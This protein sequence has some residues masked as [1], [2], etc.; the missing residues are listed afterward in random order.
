MPRLP[1]AVRFLLTAFGCYLLLVILANVT[2]FRQ[3]FAQFFAERA[4][5]SYENYLPDTRISVSPTSGDGNHDLL[6]QMLNTRTIE[7]L[8]AAARQS[9]QQNISLDAEVLNYS[10]WHSLALQIIVF[11]A[12]LVASP[13]PWK[14]KFL[15]L[16]IGGTVLLLL[17]IHRFGCSIKFKT[18]GSDL[19]EP[20]GWSA[21]T[22]GY[23][24][25]VQKM[26]SIEMTFLITVFVWLVT[27]F[28]KSDLRK[29]LG[30]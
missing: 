14:R 5:K 17:S 7:A 28:R 11:I 2:D 24:T 20:M 12:L 8:E 3:G 30:S 1:K 9:G 13:V 26:H 15:S 19:L 18:I 22:E 10:L 29:F 27:T 4:S 25:A 23:V 21:F 16:A 6:V